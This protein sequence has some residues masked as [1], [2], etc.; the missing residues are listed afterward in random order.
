MRTFSLALVFCLIL[1]PTGVHAQE[2][3]AGPQLSGVGIGGSASVRVT[4]LISV[5]AEFG[6]VPMPDVTFDADD[7]EYTL[8]PTVAGGFIGV[9]VHP[10]RGKFSLGAGIFMGGYSGEATSEPLT[11]L[12][13]IGDGEYDASQVGSLVGDFHLKGPAPA[14]M[15]GLRGRGFNI[16][17]GAAFTGA[18]DFDVNATGALRND[19]GFQRDLDREVE[20]A[21]DDVEIVTVLPIFR[22]GYEFGMR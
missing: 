15:L 12:V 6:F 13:E 19:P 8:D 16:G 9:N 20:D 14:V 11:D 4:D 18:P 17:L 5:S 10:L 3:S 22:I 1:V 21:R 7:I 2:V